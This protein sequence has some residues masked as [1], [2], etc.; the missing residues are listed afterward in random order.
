MYMSQVLHTLG[1]LC[2]NVCNYAARQNGNVCLL[3][4]VVDRGVGG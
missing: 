3:K 2:A 1:S 4:L